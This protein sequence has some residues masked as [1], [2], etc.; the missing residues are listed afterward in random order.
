MTIISRGH[1]VERISY[2]RTFDYADEPGSGFGFP[3]DEHGV[4]ILDNPAAEA[5]YAA[6]LTG[7]VDGRVIRDGGV[8][9]SVNRWWEPAVM[10]CYCGDEVVLD[11]ALTNT[12]DRCGRDYNASGQLLAPRSQWGEETGESASD[13]LMGDR[14]LT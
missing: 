6:C 13:I 14:R 10:R 7:T 4:P 8:I 11:M 1:R 2:W 9:E 3:C 5:N 12:C